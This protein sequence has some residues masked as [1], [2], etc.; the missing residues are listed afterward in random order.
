MT[1]GGSVE[2]IS[3][4]L[5]M[6]PQAV[7]RPQANPSHS[8]R[9]PTLQ[10]RLTPFR[11]NIAPLKT[12]PQ[13]LFEPNCKQDGRLTATNAGNMVFFCPFWLGLNTPPREPSAQA[14]G[15]HG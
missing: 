9:T 6:E 14:H 7:S 10:P 4:V 12:F 8:A 15:L 2:I 13:A 5:V 1:F 3:S 11:P